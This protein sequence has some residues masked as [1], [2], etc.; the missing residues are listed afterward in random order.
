MRA[1]RAS[2]FASGSSA[3]IKFGAADADALAAAKRDFQTR[4]LGEGGTE[5]TSGNPSSEFEAEFEKER[6]EAEGAYLRTEVTSMLESWGPI[7]PS[8]KKPC[9]I[10]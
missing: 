8:Q 7:I 6:L 4:P 9:L 3:G 5:L 10:Y 1:E 2:D